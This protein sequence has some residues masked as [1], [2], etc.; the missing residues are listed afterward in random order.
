MHNINKLQSTNDSHQ[1][2][3][4]LL[5][6]VG[7]PDS[8]V[9]K[10]NEMKIEGNSFFVPLKKNDNGIPLQ[11]YNIRYRQVRDGVSLFFFGCSLPLL[12]VK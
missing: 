8:P 9:L 10:T 5:L 11:S 7:E 1:S 2:H 4:I 12:S 3:S 6:S